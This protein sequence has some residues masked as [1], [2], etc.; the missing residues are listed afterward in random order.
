MKNLK[1]NKM[2][3]VYLLTDPKNHE[4]F[5]IGKGINGRAESHLKEHPQKEKAK[6][7]RIRE[8]ENRN[9]TPIVEILRSNLTSEEAFDVEAAAIDLIGKEKLTNIQNGHHKQHGRRIFSR[10]ALY[11]TVDITESNWKYLEREGALLVFINQTYDDNLSPEILYNKTRY[12]WSL[13]EKKRNKIK[14][15]LPIYHGIVQEIYK[16]VQWFRAGTT[17]LNQVVAKKDKNKW[18]FV[19]NIAE[20]SI[21]NKF[22]KKSIRNHILPSRSII[23]YVGIK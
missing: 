5:Y 1:T 21:R 3:Y 13:S 11:G 20:K 22:I 15:V 9:Q 17:V 2:Y 12:C 8:I 14:Y 18:E 6:H 16:P 7:K 4:V 10:N 23:K 19:G